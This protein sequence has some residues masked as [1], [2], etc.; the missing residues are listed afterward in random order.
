MGSAAV[1]NSSAAFEP[2]VLD[3]LDAIDFP[4]ALLNSARRVVR[5]N[6]AAG[7][8]AADDGVPGL[9]L[10]EGQYWADLCRNADVVGTAASELEDLIA[11]IGERRIVSGA[12]EYAAR[13]RG[14]FKAFRLTARALAGDNGRILVTQVDR[15]RLGVAE[16]RLLEAEQ[17]LSDIA[18]LSSDWLWGTDEELRFVELAAPRDAFWR[19]VQPSLIGRSCAEILGG[20]ESADIVETAAMAIAHQRPFR[21]CSIVIEV[22][23]KLRRIRFRGK[24][25]FDSNGVFFG[26]FGLATDITSTYEAQRRLH[27]IAELSSDWLWETDAEHRFTYV[28]DVPG[29]ISRL[30]SAKTLGRR[31][32]DLID[33]SLTDA[34]ALAR[35]ENDLAHHRS[36][37]DFVYGSTSIGRV[38]YLKISGK[39]RFDRQGCFVGHVGT[40]TDVTAIVE[41]TKQREAAERRLRAAVEQ[42]PSGIAIWDPDDRLMV[43]NQEYWKDGG[44]PGPPPIG[45]TFEEL[46]RLHCSVGRAKVGVETFEASVQQRLSLH[47]NPVGAFELAL[48]DGQVRQLDERR[49]EDG[50]T[51]SVTT[52]ITALKARERALSEQRA[53]LQTTLDHI[54][55][56]ILAIDESCRIVAVND[57]FA[58]LLDVPEELVRVG[59]HLAIVVE[60]L[61]QRGDY[62]ADR[63]QGSAGRI[64]DAISARPRWYDERPVPSGRVISWRARAMQNGG[65]IIAVADVSEQRQ[66]E[67]RREQL[68]TA[69]GQAQKLEAMSR[70]A[71][72][73]AHDLNNMLLPIMTLTEMAMDELPEGSQAR[74]DLE[75]VIGAAEHARGLVQ[76]LLTF[77]RMGAEGGEPAEID[78]SVADAMVLVR[79]TAG[80]DL[81]VRLDLRA[82]KIVVRLGVTEI[83]QVVMNL[84]LNAAQAIGDRPGTLT[85]ETGLIEENDDRL[86]GS[87]DLDSARRYARLS[88][89]DD[90]PGIPPEVLPRIFDPFF[91]TKPVGQGTGLGLA[92]VHGLVSQV[93]GAIEIICDGGARFDIL[94]PIFE[95]EAGLQNERDP[96]GTDSSDR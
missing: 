62:D 71:G 27:A 3:M 72:G 93:G 10:V 4:A 34:E 17:R 96:N 25:V 77:S 1:T 56:G 44:I 24:P 31:R 61:V 42:M 20:C 74:G 59:T 69:M 7:A 14:R 36:F 11:G 6:V 23:G 76:R 35:H 64:I 5:V 8:F 92:V 38:R 63:T 32:S 95:G 43:C 13:R 19:R 15:T 54:T 60:W 68:R 51:V 55:D 46:A 21:D 67:R 47:R 73:F 37:R 2:A 82:P 83:Q 78:A 12:V 26:Y 88:V 40:T 75:R 70:L 45:K 79:A 39:P 28:S 86:R 22:E 66:A 57:T 80:P 58:E 33:R 9:R 30:G 91:T 52:D 16:R 85:I 90:G 29:N 81:A 18:E 50:T 87:A 65:R 48:E 49:L 94:L 84:G 41:A 53:L 89:I